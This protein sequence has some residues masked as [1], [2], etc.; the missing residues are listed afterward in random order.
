C[1]GD[2][3]VSP[4][5]VR[6]DGDCVNQFRLVRTWTFTDRCGNTSSV[7]QTI[8]VDDTTAPVITAPAMDETVECDGAGNLDELDAWLA[9]NGGAEAT[10]NCLGLRWIND[11]DGLSDECGATGE[12]TVT[13]T[14]IDDCGNQASTTATFTIEDTRPPMITGPLPNGATM[15]VECNLRDP[16][17]N[18]F[19]ITVDDLDIS[20]ECSGNAEINVDYE[21]VLL[22]EGE[23]GVSD[24]LSLWRCRWTATDDCGLS[25]TYTIFVRII[26]T[27]PPVWLESTFPPDQAL[28]CEEDI[29]FVEPQAEDACADV[30]VT[31]RER[32]IPGDC[33]HSF[34]VV[35]T[36]T[37]TDG[38][39]NATSRD[40]R[41]NISDETP[42]VLTLA[43]S[44][45]REYDPF[46]DVFISCTEYTNIIKLRAAVDARDN[47][48]SDLPIE[49]W[50]E[51][52]N[53]NW[54]CGHQDVPNVITYWRT[55]DDCGNETMIFLRWFLVDDEAPILVDVPEDAC[56]TELP[57]VPR[58]EAVDGCGF[59]TVDFEQS[60]PTDCG[61][62]VLVLRTWTATDYCGNTSMATQRLT[63]M[64]SDGPQVRIDFPG[65]RNAVNGST[66]RLP[67]TDCIDLLP[68]L[69]GFLDI[70]E[71]CTGVQYDFEQTLLTMGNCATDGFLAAYA[72]MITAED[73]CG[74]TT[75]YGLRI[76][77]I[78]TEGPSFADVP[79][80]I[81][82]SCGEEIPLPGVSDACSGVASVTGNDLTMATV[83]CEG[84]ASAYRRLWMATDSCGNTST[85]EQLISIVDRT[86]PVFSGLPEDGCNSL[87]APPIVTAFDECEG[88]AVAVNF[89]EEMLEGPCGQY[90]ARTWT[91]TDACGNTSE[92]VRYIYFNDNEAP[93]LTLVDPLLLGLE[94]GDDKVLLTS[95]PDYDPRRYLDLDE[96]AVFVDDNCAIRSSVRLVRSRQV[97]R[98][99][100]ADGFVARHTY[101]WIATD[102]CG[103]ESSLMITV[104][105]LDTYAPDIFNVPD[106]L[107]LYCE[108][109]VPAPGTILAVDDFTEEVDVRFT[110]SRRGMS[111]G[112][113]IT[114]TWTATDECGNQR[115]ASQFIDIFE[116]T[117][118]CAIQPPAELD[119][120]TSGNTISVLVD[121]GTAPYHYQWEM[122]DCDGFITAGENE[123]RMTFTVGYTTQN[124]RVSITD[125][126]GCERVC[127]LSLECE[128]PVVPEEARVGGLGN[129]LPLRGIYPNPANEEVYL[130]I[131]EVAELDGSLTLIDAYG[132]VVWQQQYHK[133]PVGK[134]RIAVDHLPAGVYFARLQ[135]ADQPPVLQQFIIQH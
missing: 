70:R 59:A 75:N 102:P 93:T 7:S 66:V 44:Y 58:V 113:R 92:A 55:T 41:F 107:V 35:R 38:C 135:V 12:A 124:F 117:I 109:P 131:A 81:T 20:D 47:C 25:T 79:S 28:S 115:S 57:P 4:T 45:V 5:E 95:D 22:E 120:N 54:G 50:Y 114:R 61:G 43:D 133:V 63:M 88:M 77:M 67:A 84:S 1:D 30:E 49:F 34:T 119:C 108:D 134:L 27:R 24:F 2:I 126:N 83:G 86:G 29:P 19:S 36:W 91:A 11:F 72:I 106:N 37:A 15:E 105:F 23:C 39:G 112:E 132:K 97:S 74:N 51:T 80:A 100:A 62:G 9:S 122:N 65:L 17:W 87:T 10:D 16:N 110:Q 46:Q 98:D 89:N 130:T 26:D 90:V 33:T 85:F 21:E 6:T 48:D 104:T 60:E 121:G 128:K 82:L 103:N 42:P 76:E 125:A 78:D 111:F 56:V 96:S 101:R 68:D 69:K 71:G 40:Q 118:T 32:I 94:D 127:T 31:F 129:I 52:P 8:E 18:P 99:C 123:Q 64:D 116:N 53:T 14:A 13:F 3:T 73:G